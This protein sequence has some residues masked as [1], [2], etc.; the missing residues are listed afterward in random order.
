MKNK[1]KQI[2]AITLAVLLL[3]SMLPLVSADTGLIFFWVQSPTDMDLEVMQGENVQ[4]E[5]LAWAGNNYD[6]TVTVYDSNDNEVTGVTAGDTALYN[7][8]G[9]ANEVVSINTAYLS[10]DYTVVAWVDDGDGSDE[11]TLYLTVTEEVNNMPEVIST[12]PTNVDE[13]DVYSYTI[14]VYDADCDQITFEEYLMPNWASLD[15]GSQTFDLGSCVSGIDLLGTAPESDGTPDDDWD[16]IVKATDE[17]GNIIYDQW[18]VTVNDLDEPQIDPNEIGLLLYWILD[19]DEDGIFDDATTDDQEAD[20]CDAAPSFE[21]LSWASEGYDIEVNLR[22]GGVLVANLVTDSDANGDDLNDYLTLNP[23]YFVNGAGTYTVEATVTTDS[24]VS[25]TEELNVVVTGIDT[26]GDGDG[27]A[28]DTPQIGTIADQ[29]VDEGEILEVTF[30]ME[31]PNGDV[32]T[33]EVLVEAGVTEDLYEVANG[34]A[35]TVTDNGDGTATLTLHPMYTFVTHPEDDREFEISV[36]AT[37]DSATVVETFDVTVNDVN[38]IPE[39]I[40]TASTSAT[41]GEEYTYEFD[42]YDYDTEDDLVYSLLTAPVGIVI[43]EDAQTLTWTPDYDTYADGDQVDVEIMV[44]DY[45]EGT[46]MGG[47]DTQSWQITITNTN[48]APEFDSLG[49]QTVAEDE[50]LEF[51][52]SSTDPD[53]NAITLSA[54]DLPASATFTDN[55][56]GTGDFS[57][58]P[59][60]EDSADSPYFVTFTAEDDG[61]PVMDDTMTIQ[62]TVDNT[63]RAPELTVYDGQTVNEGDT[64]IIYMEATDEDGDELEFTMEAPAEFEDQITFTD[65]GDGTAIFEWDVGYDAAGDQDFTFTVT[66]GQAD[67]SETVTLSVGNVNLA[68]EIDVEDQTA[69]EGETLEYTFNVTDFDGDD[70]TFGFAADY[71]EDVTLS[72]NNDG[73]WTFTWVIDY[74]Q[75]D[76][77]GRDHDFT[78]IAEDVNLDSTSETFTVTVYDVNGA[79]IFLSTPDT[80]GTVGEEYT[81][82]AQADDPEG[83]PITYDVDGPSGMTIDEES[84]LVEWTPSSMGSFYV[85]V[86]ASDDRYTTAQSYTINVLV[87]QHN[88]KYSNVKFDDEDVMS[89]DTVLLSVG[90]ANDGDADLDNLQISAVV[91][92]LGLKFVSEEFDLDQGEQLSELV[93]FIIPEDARDGQYDVKITV[94]NDD[95]HHQTYRVLRVSES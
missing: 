15:F 4:V 83:E 58:T 54:A 80:T 33:F 53:G 92:N 35:I 70:F 20:Y 40:T 1:T 55:G 56:D 62:I 47:S 48:R 52:V 22:D 14:E 32:L 91:Y 61:T 72:N 18:I 43:D 87:P 27:D 19:T 63:N 50:L 64:V 76:D 3:F 7:Y 46:S 44:E 74:Y 73:T 28:C 77:N 23:S 29:E 89:G 90:M 21:Y 30:D 41:E 26:D 57:W 60:Y 8:S 84:G 11:I 86:Y 37:D 17:D 42:A 34:E 94:S 88:V 67:D 95:F 10:G 6:L 59:D 13:H 65:N 31:D 78:L 16:F 39:F 38:L 93:E 36:Q 81:Y 24:G 25:Q 82:L 12:P 68:P 51:T 75:G 69:Y 85:T 9:T 66:D 49:D 79:P 5:Y 2:S 45:S 71:G